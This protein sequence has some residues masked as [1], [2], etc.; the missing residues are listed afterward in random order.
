MVLT[1]DWARWTMN[2][3]VNW[4]QPFGEKRGDDRGTL[5][6]NLATGY[7]LLPWLQPEIGLNYGREFDAGEDDGTGVAVTK[8]LFVEPQYPSKAADAIARESG[9]RMYT[10]DPAVTGAMDANAYLEIM[11][12]NLTQLQKALKRP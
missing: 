4:S 5:A 10:L 12:R 9:A 6:A 7:Q 2:G 1:K 8:A 3:E 11:E